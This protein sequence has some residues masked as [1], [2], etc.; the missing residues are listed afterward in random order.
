MIRGDLGAS[1]DYGIDMA[2]RDRGTK[3]I[4]RDLNNDI[5]LRVK[6]QKLSRVSIDS[7]SKSRGKKSGTR[8][9]A[10]SERAQNKEGFLRARTREIA[11]Q[12]TRTGVSPLE[13]ML[14]NMRWAHNHSVD[15]LE[16]LQDFLVAGTDK[17]NSG[18]STGKV[19]DE[20]DESARDL[21]R[22]F[23]R[24]RELAQRFAVDAAPYIH[25]RLAQVEWKP[26]GADRKLARIQRVI[27]DPA[28]RDATEIPPPATAAKI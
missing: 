14:T 7:E 27:I 2:K 4:D 28:N 23:I 22:Q 6:A 20:Q 12:A 24:M 5:E 11:E 26:D 16:N 8:K 3:P 10:V 9:T 13:V 15:L 17:R 25:P 1:P 21:L 18:G 19:R